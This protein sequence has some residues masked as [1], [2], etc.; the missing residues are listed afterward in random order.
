MQNDLSLIRWF[1]PWYTVRW[2]PVHF[3]RRKQF[4]RNWF[5]HVADPFGSNWFLRCRFWHFGFC[6]FRSKPKRTVYFLHTI[7]ISVWATPNRMCENAI[8]VVSICHKN[9]NYDFSCDS[10]IKM[11]IRV[12]MI[13]FVVTIFECDFSSM[14]N[15]L[16]AAERERSPFNTV[17]R[18][19]CRSHSASRTEHT[20]ENLFNVK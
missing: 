16:F 10:R 1:L 7:S 12:R 13:F 4:H 18:L 3:P 9:E 6:F 20:T 14:N 19:L 17:R 11:C 8:S 2:C 15:Y 5:A